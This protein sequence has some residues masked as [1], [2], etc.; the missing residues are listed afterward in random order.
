MRNRIP[1]AS[2]LQFTDP[3]RTPVTTIPTPET[4]FPVDAKIDLTVF[5][6]ASSFTN[7][8][9]S[10][11]A[12]PRVY[13]S[14]PTTRIPDRCDVAGTPISTT[15]PPKSCAPRMFKHL[16]GAKSKALPYVH[17]NTKG[18]ADHLGS[19][20]SD[21]VSPF[22]EKQELYAAAF[23]LTVT[24]EGQ[25]TEGRSITSNVREVAGGRAGRKGTVAGANATDGTEA[26]GVVGAVYRDELGEIWWD[27]QEEWEFA[28]L[29]PPIK[30]PLSAQY[31]NVEG[32]V[33]YNHLKEF[34]R[35]DPS[36]P[37]SSPSSKL[38]DFYHSCPLLVTD[39]DSEQLVRGHVM[40]CSSIAG[41]I[42]LPSPS[43]EASNILL[44]IP[45]RP[46][47]GRHLKPGFLEDVIV[48]PPTPTPPSASSHASCPPRSPARAA[49]FIIN[50]SA[51]SGSA[52]RQRSRSRSLS[53][54]K[55]K[56]APPPLKIMPIC[57]VDKLAVNVDPE[58]EDRKIHLE[59]PFKPKPQAVTSRWSR[60]TTA[61]VRLGD[62]NNQAD[63]FPSVDAP[64]KSRRLGMFFDTGERDFWDR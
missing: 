33:T 12:T 52:K 62:L 44:A 5:G 58:V 13:G 55:R 41:S 25:V 8:P 32:W 56:P 1:P 6:Y 9:V 48:V 21:S 4:P 31:P 20:V 29:L 26:A 51:K 24:Q 40:R 3:P 30:V 46:K 16:F 47:R 61:P 49:R 2:F 63:D 22:P 14:K 43:V 15:L 11:P 59:D 7:I 28:H 36:E 17:T 60:E 27:Q 10:T 57:S 53:R 35:E 19:G 45:S 39:E 38:T 64:K 50:T 37:Y 54:R 42:V 18:V 23:P 34:E